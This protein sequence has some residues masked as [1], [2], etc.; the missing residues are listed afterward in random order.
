MLHNLSM[1]TDHSTDTKVAANKP[2]DVNITTNALT[3]SHTSYNVIGPLSITAMMRRSD[4]PHKVR[5][6][7]FKAYMVTV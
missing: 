5:C 7:D 6:V 3:Q 1:A 2:Q 4:F